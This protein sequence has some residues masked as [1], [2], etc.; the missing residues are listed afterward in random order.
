MYRGT[1]DYK[2]LSSTGH[3]RTISF[4]MYFTAAKDLQNYIDI[5]TNWYEVEI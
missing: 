4:A 5:E 1:Y 3:N 2:A